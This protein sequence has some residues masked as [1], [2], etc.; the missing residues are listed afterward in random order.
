MANSDFKAMWS[1]LS[2]GAIDAKRPA[3]VGVER[4]H[5]FIRHVED[6]N[7]N[8]NSVA[9]CNAILCQDTLKSLPDIELMDVMDKAIDILTAGPVP[10]SLLAA[11]DL[12]GSV[13]RRDSVIDHIAA[14]QK[15]AQQREIKERA[16]NQK[17]FKD[18][19]KGQEKRQGLYD[20]EEK[21]DKYCV[22]CSD[23]RS[24][25][26]TFPTREQAMVSAKKMNEAN[27][28]GARTK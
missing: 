28:R 17:S 19:W 26:G 25:A 9:V 21:G 24:V 4:W 8:V 23:D 22:I 12:E 13:T 11:Q 10:A 5:K 18:Y 16:P 20:V 14:N 15:K 3:G 6:Y 1:D 27:V 7:K 2:K